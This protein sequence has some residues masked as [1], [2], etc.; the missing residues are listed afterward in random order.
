MTLLYIGDPN[1]DKNRQYVNM[2]M[3]LISRKSSPMEYWA[4]NPTVTP[5]PVIES[6]AHHS[7][8]RQLNRRFYLIQKARDATTFGILVGTLSQRHFTRAVTVLQQTILAA[9]RACYTFAVGKLNPAKLANFGEIDAYV[10]VACP[11]HSLLA[12]DREFHVPVITPLEVDICLG[13]TEWGEYSLDYNDF[14]R[15][16]QGRSNQEDSN[17]VD[18]APYFS[19]ISGTLK[20]SRKLSVDREEVD[21]QA[22]PGQGQLMTNHSA[23]AEYLKNRSYQGLDTQ[24]GKTEVHAAKMGQTGIASHYNTDDEKGKKL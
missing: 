12:D 17:H 13:N 23:G 9:N 19:L 8:S 5:S 18:D 14:I 11:E 4:L 15:T 24:L 7:I 2:M 20:D 3:Q 6:D 22:L 16:T 10:L 1:A 21:L